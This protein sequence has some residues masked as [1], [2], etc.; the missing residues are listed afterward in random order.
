MAAEFLADKLGVHVEY[1]VETAC[2]SRIMQGERLNICCSCR[3]RLLAGSAGGRC[4]GRGGAARGSPGSGHVI[5]AVVGAVQTVPALAFL[6]LLVVFLTGSRAVPAIIA[7]FCYSL[8]PIAC[9]AY[10]GLH[11]ILADST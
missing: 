3:S 4:H 9:S 6:V 11:D 5:L 1:H 2:S 10:T 7:L 8:L